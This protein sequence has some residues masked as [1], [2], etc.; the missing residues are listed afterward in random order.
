MSKGW[1]DSKAGMAQAISAF[2]PTIGTE[3]THEPFIASLAPSAPTANGVE[4]RIA[5][6]VGAALAPK[7]RR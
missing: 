2:V 1:N 3:G 5:D 7:V 6:R 4:P